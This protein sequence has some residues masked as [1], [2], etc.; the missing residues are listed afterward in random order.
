[1]KKLLTI[2]SI[3]VLTGALLFSSAFAQKVETVDG[4]KIVKNDKPKWGNNPKVDIEL[5]KRI[6][7]LDGED[8]NFMFYLPVGIT[9]DQS[10]NLYILDGGNYRVQKLDPEGRYLKTLGREG[11]GPGE[12]SMP[13]SIDID[14]SGNLYISDRGNNRVQVLD[15]NGRNQDTFTFDEGVDIVKLD[16]EG[17]VIKTSSGGFMIRMGGEDEE[18]EKSNLLLKKYDKNQE[19]I[20][21]FIEPK[22]YD[23]M[24]M[25]M[26]AN[27]FNYNVGPD[28]SIYVNFKYQN[29]IEKYSPDGDLVMQIQRK[30][31]DEPTKPGEGGGSMNRDGGNITMRAPKLNLLANGIDVDSKGRIWSIKTVRQEKEEETVNQ[32][33]SISADA[34]GA[35][36]TSTKLEGNTELTETDMFALEVFNSDGTLLADF[37]L[38]HFA[39]DITILGDRIYILDKLRGS[40]F[41]E[42]KIIE[43]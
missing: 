30:T 9:A 11:Q 37:P 38:T 35:R 41:F 17:N 43:K 39:N 16:S 4:V 8:D 1:M 31:N 40:M 7:E 3:L 28:G 20:K 15:K 24:M 10:G 21:D 36:S 5:V 27:R 19:H 18:G 42:Y 13:A 6:G 33:M 26:M 25:N 12:F 32:M 34:S 2:I 14:K 23:D 29:R 22:E